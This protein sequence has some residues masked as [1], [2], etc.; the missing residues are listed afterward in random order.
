MPQ[1]AHQKNN[2]C[3]QSNLDKSTND[4][5]QHYIFKPLGFFILAAVI[6]LGEVEDIPIEHPHHEPSL[7]D[8]HS[9]E[10]KVREVSVK[11]PYDYHFEQLGYTS[12]KE[13][14]EES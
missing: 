14:K 6:I 13:K 8:K 1:V 5:D 4:H 7:C 11:S 2:K 3:E 10:F 12:E 9:D